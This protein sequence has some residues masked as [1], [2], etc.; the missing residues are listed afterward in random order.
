MKNLFDTIVAPVTP[1]TYSG[2]GI[3]LHFAG[4]KMLAAVRRI[5][6]GQAGI[7]HHI[8]GITGRGGREAQQ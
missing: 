5:K 3:G 6:G 4:E 1:L 2:V 7:Q 8:N